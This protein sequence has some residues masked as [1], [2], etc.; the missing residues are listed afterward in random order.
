[1]N[2]EKFN[3]ELRKFLKKLGI[4]CQREIE[5]AVRTALEQDTLT[6]NETLSV[7]AKVTIQEL[8]METNVEGEIE[9]E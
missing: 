7:V 6:G 1:M 2:E 9:L 4:T 3:M 8:G 5:N